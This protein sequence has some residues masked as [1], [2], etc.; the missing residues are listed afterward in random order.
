MDENIKNGINYYEQTQA[1][2]ANSFSVQ[3]ASSVWRQNEKVGLKY[4]ED[5]MAS[6]Q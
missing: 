3:L 1:P 2:H 6:Q 5:N 4:W